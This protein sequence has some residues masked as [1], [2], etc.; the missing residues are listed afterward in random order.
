MTSP[1]SA[2]N[3]APMHKTPPLLLRAARPLV[4]LHL[5]IFNN[6]DGQQN[7]YD[8]EYNVLRGLHVSFVTIV[9]LFIVVGEGK[10]C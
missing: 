4:A 2:K 3:C 9:P 8:I 7:T 1:D 6:P 10:L 5:F